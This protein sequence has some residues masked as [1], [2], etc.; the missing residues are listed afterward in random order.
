MKRVYKP[1]T[2]RDDQI[3][4][5]KKIIRAV[6]NPE[7][8]IHP[9]MQK[10]VIRFMIWNI[11][12]VDYKYKIRYQ[13]QNVKNDLNAPIIHEHVFPLKGLIGAL[14]SFFTFWL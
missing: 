3:N 11:T 14:R 10:K 6:L 4:D 7:N 8:D 2:K 12:G 13:S 9:E 1:Y 5:A